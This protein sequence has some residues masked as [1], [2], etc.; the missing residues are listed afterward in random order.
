MKQ[1][2]FLRDA[3]TFFIDKKKLEDIVIDKNTII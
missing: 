2:L 1:L 3:Q